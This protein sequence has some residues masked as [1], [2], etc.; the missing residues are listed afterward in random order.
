MTIIPNPPSTGDEFTNELTGVTYRYDGEK[1]LAVSAPGNEALDALTERVADGETKQSEI[2]GTIANAL[3]VQANKVDKTGDTMTGRLDAPRIHVNNENSSTGR[4]FEVQYDGDVN[5]WMNANGQIRTN[6]VLNDDTEFKTLTT[7]QYVDNKDAEILDT[8]SEIQN[9]VSTLEAK[10]DALEATVLDGKWQLDTRSVAGAGKFLPLGLSGTATEWSEVVKLQ[11][12][13]TSFDNRSFTFAEVA[14]DDVVRL[15]FSGSSAAFKVTSPFVQTGDVYEATVQL[16]SS[17]GQP[18]ETIIYDFEFLP[19]FDPTAYATIDYVDAQDDLVKGYVDTEIG[20]IVVPDVSGFLPKSGGT[21]TGELKINRGNA[22]TA[23]RLQQDGTDK[24]KLWN[25]NSEARLQV[26][27]GQVFKVTGYVDDS[28]KQL[29]GVSSTGTVTLSN[30]RSPSNAKDAATKAYVD[31]LLAAP[32]RLS[33][34]WDTGSGN[35]APPT[36]AFKYTATGGDNY[37]RF[38]FETYNGIKLGESV[39][40]DFNR[41]IDNGPVG[42]IWYKEANGWKF[43]QQFRIN[44]FRWNYNNHFEFRV[45]SR[46]GSTSFTPGT[47]YY[48]TIGGFF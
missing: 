5:A 33:W 7:K 42:T 10:V 38:S 17:E 43:K 47:P 35:D 46:N 11:M 20:N 14:V 27:N 3:V 29:F 40:N 26:F 41:G 18:F 44:T 21:M 25:T 45:T 31:S 15:G 48:I 39:I 30:L 4:V 28:I 8:Q 1:W 36:G 23:I 12:N 32:A 22:S 2:E 37:Y 13:P 24:I 34:K 16:L 19:S 6:F 9:D